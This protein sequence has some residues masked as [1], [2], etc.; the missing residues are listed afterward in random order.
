MKKIICLLIL[1][2]L[3]VSCNSY[4]G[5]YTDSFGVNSMSLNSD[6]TFETA[7]CN[8]KWEEVEGGIK[9]YEVNSNGFGRSDCNY[10]GFYESYKNSHNGAQSFEHKNTKVC[11]IKN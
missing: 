4:S 6:G 2:L 8:G 9:V 10:E 7:S 11:W 1:Q 5:D 3:I